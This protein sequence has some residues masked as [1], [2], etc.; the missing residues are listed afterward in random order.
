MPER[1]PTRRSG[2]LVPLF[3]IPTAASWGIGEIADLP[4][5]AAWARSCGLSAIQLLPINEMADGQSSPYSAL[6][7]M[8]IDPIFIAVRDVPEVIAAGEDALTLEQRDLLD[9]VRHAEAVEYGAVRELK[10]GV[11]REAFSRFVETEWRAVQGAARRKRTPLL[12]R[13]AGGA[14]VARAARDR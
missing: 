8:A 4:A 10:I 2:V 11:L 14:P 6:S 5:F 1:H 7:A 13:V 9:D 3:S 12:D